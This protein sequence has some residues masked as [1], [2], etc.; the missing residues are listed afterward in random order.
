[1]GDLRNGSLPPSRFLNPPSDGLPANFLS[2]VAVRGFEPAELNFLSLP[3]PPVELLFGLSSAE[4][5]LPE[6]D[7]L[8]GAAKD[9]FSPGVSLLKLL[10]GLSLLSAELTLP[11]YGLL[12]P[13]EYGFFSPD[14]SLPK[15]LLGLS[16]LS[17]GRPE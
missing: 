12:R 5:S 10:F 15:L 6:Y 8:R 9:F 7:F 11:E 4:L 2:P 1:M 3:S 16:S 17:A 14:E 13:E